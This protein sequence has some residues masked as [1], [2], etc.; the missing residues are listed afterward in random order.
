MLFHLSIEADDPRHVAH[1]FAELWQSEAFPFP[2][3]MDGSWVAFA[4]DDRGT[5]IEVYPRGTEI[6]PG[7]GDAVGV[8]SAHRRHNPTHMAIGTDLTE[9]RVL[10]ICKR[11]G[12]AAKYCKRGGAF[13]VLEIFVEV[14]QMIEV[15]TPQMQREYLNAVTIPNWKA[16][17]AARAG[18]APEKLA[19]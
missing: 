9:E 17:L 13:G 3:V 2:S 8:M 11:E 4:G 7:E 15:L 16:M 19:A 6:H 12:W 10:D 14:C 5:I 18:A 1:V